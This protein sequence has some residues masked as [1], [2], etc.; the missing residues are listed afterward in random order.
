MNYKMVSCYSL[1]TFQV[2]D[3]DNVELVE[4]ETYAEG[5]ISWALDRIDQVGST[6]NGKFEPYGDG[7][8]VDI[9]ILDSGKNCSKNV[10]T[11]NS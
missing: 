11:F 2:K 4:E 8:G 7:E 5:T 10:E 1:V 6:L 9:Y 3:L